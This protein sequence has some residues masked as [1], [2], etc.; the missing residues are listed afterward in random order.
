MSAA[1]T[2]IPTEI[3]S[4]SQPMQAQ[5]NASTMSRKKQEKGQKKRGGGGGSRKQGGGHQSAGLRGLE[6][7]PPAVR[8]SKTI[9]WLL[10]H[11]A[12]HERLS[13]R[14][15]GYVKVKDLVRSR[16]RIIGRVLII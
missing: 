14:P 1:E 8:L 12:Q 3:I 5:R 10:R 16:I 13:M 4:E 15:D 6:K 11:G 9:S 7:D 2:P